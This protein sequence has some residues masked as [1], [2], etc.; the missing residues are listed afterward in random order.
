MCVWGHCVE[1][2]TTQRCRFCGTKICTACLRGDFVG[3][4]VDLERCMVCHSGNRF[5]EAIP[6]P[7]ARSY[8]A[9]H[10]AEIRKQKAEERTS[11][12][13]SSKRSQG[14]KVKVMTKKKSKKEAKK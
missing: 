12:K 14:S 13:A 3:V 1:T 10:L 8:T 7:H 2:D 9:E 11:A 6:N 4:A 5:L